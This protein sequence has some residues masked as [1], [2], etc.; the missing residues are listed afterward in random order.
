[1]LKNENSKKKAD[2]FDFTNITI[3]EEPLNLEELIHEI[4]KK[5]LEKFNGNKTKTAEF[6]G[7][8]RI[9]LYGRFKL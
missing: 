9:Q 4:I 1:M 7:L 2:N 6:L 3:P 5:T 8:S